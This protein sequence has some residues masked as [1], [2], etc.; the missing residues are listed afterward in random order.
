MNNIEIRGAC[1]H[2]LQSVDVDIPRHQFVCVTGVSGSGKSSLVFHTLYT[3]AQRQLVE[4]FS[5]FA[6]RRLPKLS[7][8]PVDSIRNI[9]TPIVIDQK[10]MGK[11]L[12]STVGTATEIHTY[13]RMLYSRFG[14]PQIGPS[15]YFSFNNPE[16]MCPACQGLG[17][18]IRINREMIYDPARSL[19]DG[20]ITHP[21]FKVGG[22][23]WRQAVQ[24]G[25]FNP[26]LPLG[27]WPQKDL[28][29]L[30]YSDSISTTSQMAGLDVNLRF[31]GIISRLER[32]YINK[33]EDDVP[34]NRRDAYQKFLVYQDCEV[35]AGTR[36]NDRARSVVLAG[37]KL[38]EA[39]RLE[40]ADLDDWV[41][42]LVIPQAKAIVRKVR[43]I[44]KPLVQIGAGYLSLDRSVATLSGGESQRVKMARQ[45]DC[46]LVELMYLLDEPSVG[47]HPRD[48]ETLIG[49]LRDLRDRGN[50]VLVVEHDPDIILAADQVIEIGP[51][52]GRHGGRV[53]FQGL[54]RDL[55]SLAHLQV[56]R[57]NQ[58]G[59]SQA[60]TNQVVDSKTIAC[61]P[62]ASQPCRSPKGF[63][64]IRNARLHNLQGVDV[65]IPQ[66]VLVGVSGVSGSGKSSLIHGIF[67]PSQPGAIVVGQAAPGKSSRSMALT[68]LGIFDAVRN[69]LAPHFGLEAS[70]LS[71]NGGGACPACKGAGIIRLEMSFMDDVESE[72]EECG[73]QRYRPEVLAKTWQG[74]TMA[75]IL[76]TSVDD[77][78]VLFAE[79]KRAIRAPLQS[80]AEVGLGYLHIGQPLSE[81]S[82]GEAQRL[83]L[84]SELHKAGE[85]YI[86]DEPTTGLHTRD[87]AILRGI[88]QRLVA[89]GNSVVVV[90]HNLELLA[91]CD[92]IIDMGPEGGKRG[93]QIVACGSPESIASCPES[94][95]GQHLQRVL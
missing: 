58:A 65:D 25:L 14:S 57:T 35:C 37:L 42:G 90:E 49:L 70:L 89:Q 33:G 7:R 52:A 74:K 3:E 34:E 64:P 95:T 92:W 62:C 84:A 86:L 8:P 54:P 15:F 43:G 20:A 78:L 5:T 72:C 32:L 85:L 51:G 24:C 80:L 16:G 40:L 60:V 63:W 44:L 23:F 93:G 27:Q 50:S 26:D 13:L 21:E 10:A 30:F 2:N 69:F 94:L 19:R 48:T 1:T 39:C 59:A 18:R 4:T 56:P 47:L 67:A 11:T 31:E 22:Y 79:A 75:Q 71:F 29:T 61:Q 9:S 45:L 36:L 28:Q 66:G 73:G 88:L 87:I 46:D 6:Q 38:E 91:D 68:W 81:L 55:L 77:A 12:R 41:A 76:E 83:K 53:L 82:G 17:R